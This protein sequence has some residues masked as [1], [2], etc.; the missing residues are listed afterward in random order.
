MLA[1][2]LHPSEPPASLIENITYFDAADLWLTVIKISFSELHTKLNRVLKWGQVWRLDTVWKEEGGRERRQ[3]WGRETSGGFGKVWLWGRLAG[4]SVLGA[5]QGH[6]KVRMAYVR[7][8]G[9]KRAILGLAPM[10]KTLVRGE[11]W[12]LLLGGVHGSVLCPLLWC[13][14]C[15]HSNCG[16][17]TCKN[18]TDRLIIV[19]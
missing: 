18:G 7:V 15:E 16:G 6:N 14:G 2:P 3:A 4:Q 5:P 11:H 13:H 10:V 9:T 19:P 12:V 8:V 17:T 1:T